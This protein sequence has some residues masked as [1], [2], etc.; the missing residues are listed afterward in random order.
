MAFTP[1]GNLQ[2][3]TLW[4][5]SH[6]LCQPPFPSQ[7]KAQWHCGAE[8]LVGSLQ[9][10]IARATI[11][12]LWPT[13]KPPQIYWSAWHSVFPCRW[14]LCTRCTHQLYLH[15]TALCWVDTHWMPHR[16]QNQE[17]H[18]SNSVMAYNKFLCAQI[19]FLV[20]LLGAPSTSSPKLGQGNTNCLTHT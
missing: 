19:C 11:H 15:L 8:A 20:L 1:P 18:G 9:D 6:Y 16:K 14:T 3:V 10:N 17:T 7:R 4:K 5:P 12:S 2:W 13:S